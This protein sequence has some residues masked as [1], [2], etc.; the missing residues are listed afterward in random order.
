MTKYNKEDGL[1]VLESID[2]AATVNWGNQW[3]MPTADEIMELKRSN[4]LQK[5]RYTLNGVEGLLC[6]A[7]NGNSIFFRK[8]YVQ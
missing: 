2:D 4:Q 5:Q 1:T 7:S 6:T 3:R 8:H